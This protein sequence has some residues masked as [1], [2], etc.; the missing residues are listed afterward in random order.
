[1][2]A[3]DPEVVEQKREMKQQTATLKEQAKEAKADIRAQ[4]A[5]KPDA[6][7]RLTDR[8]LTL[9]ELGGVAGLVYLLRKPLEKFSIKVLEEIYKGI[10][11]IEDGLKTAESGVEAAELRIRTDL[12][13][14]YF[15]D[16]ILCHK[17]GPNLYTQL[18]ESAAWDTTIYH[19]DSSYPSAVAD[20]F[21]AG[22]GRGAT[23][24]RGS[25]AHGVSLQMLAL[26]KWFA[27]NGADL[28][29]LGS[30]PKV[31]PPII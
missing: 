6:A 10:H 20:L 16:P 9:I 26:V 15:E 21:L 5:E 12:R 27:G 29:K 13:A 2:S 14:R 4:K 19:A 18:F 25:V 31:P 28:Q 1:M 11:V 22:T 8:L 24:L 7:K 23:Q 3:A 17:L 30:F